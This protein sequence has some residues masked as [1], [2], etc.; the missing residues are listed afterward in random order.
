[1]Q[2]R[3][4]Y[5]TIFDKERAD[6][7]QN[8]T[9]V[10]TVAQANSQKMKLLRLVELLRQETDEQNPLTTTEILDRLDAAGISCDRRTLYKD[11]ALLNEQG[12]E[13]MNCWVSREKGYYIEDRSFSVP[14]LKILIDAV[15]ASSF[16]TEK[17]TAELIAKIANLGGSH[18]AELLRGSMVC[19]NT[20]KHSNEAIYYNVG[21]LEGAIQQQKQVAFRY[22]DLKANRGKE[23]RKEGNS[24]TV[25][26]VAL[27]F[28]EDNYY[29]VGYS[30]KYGKTANYRVDRM[31]QVA[32]MENGISKEA[33][34]LRTEIS[35]YTEQVFKMYDGPVTEVTLAFDKQLI[36]V[37]FDK[38]GEETRIFETGGDCCQTTVQVQ[39]SPVFWGWLFQFAGQ[40]DILRPESLSAA[41][42]KRAASLL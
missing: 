5:D 18:R 31:D 27:V 34:A 39:V 2:D 15:Q 32:C 20:R 26:P 29:L 41:Y 21:A 6:A 22:F 24:Y 9:G 10:Y 3:T 42:K 30:A 11:I 8:A 14:E 4:I 1:M 23:Y 7:A 36:G 16:I 19:F 35:S 28:Y 17:K 33:L 38:F 40:M 37:V 12:F 13:V 25:E